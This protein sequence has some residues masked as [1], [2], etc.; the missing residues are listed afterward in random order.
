MVIGAGAAGAVG[1]DAGAGPGAGT[2]GGRS[3]APLV[4]GADTPALGYAAVPDTALAPPDLGGPA[5]SPDVGAVVVHAAMAIAAAAATAAWIRRWMAMADQSVLRS[6]Q[7]R[8]TAPTGG[9]VAPGLLGPARKQEKEPPVALM[10]EGSTG[11]GET[12][13]V[14]S[15]VSYD[16]QGNVMTAEQVAAQA[17]AA[18]EAKAAAD[19]AAAQAA[20]EAAAADAAAAA[21]ATAAAA[22]AAAAPVERTYTVV[23]GDT[24]SAIGKKFGV[25][26]RDIASLNQVKNPDLIHPGQV[27]RIPN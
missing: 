25:N 6:L 26:W 24:L 19:A 4:A 21:A 8:L 20:A 17:A 10:E 27:F 7:A 3:A 18:A 13:E 11:A 22:A 9:L 1:V 5:A 15:S 12:L 14:V 16:A 23:K 2:T